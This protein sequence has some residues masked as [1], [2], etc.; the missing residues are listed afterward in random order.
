MPHEACYH[1]PY[2]KTIPQLFPQVAPIIGSDV[3]ALSVDGLGAFAKKVTVGQLADYFGGAVIPRV[4]TPEMFGAQGGT[5][6][7]TVAVQTAVNA[8]M[9]VEF[10]ASGAVVLTRLYRTSAPIT[11]TAGAIDIIAISAHCGLRLD[12]TGNGFEVGNAAATGGARIEDVRFL[13]VYVAQ[14]IVGTNGVA[15][16]VYNT[17]RLRMTNCNSVGV[18][19]CVQLGESSSNVAATDSVQQAILEGCFLST[20][21]GDAIRIPSAAIV[22]IDDCMGNASGAAGTAFVRLG[23][24][25][26]NVDGIE[27]KGCTAENFA[28]GIRC[29][30]IGAAN[31]R[32][33]D[34][35]VDRNSEGGIFLKPQAGGVIQNFAIYANEIGLNVDILL[36]V[37][38][39]MDGS[40]SGAS[41]VKGR[42]FGNNIY[43]FGGP[44]IL[45]NEV[46]GANIFG[47][48]IEDCGGF[49][50]AGECSI[51]IINTTRWT[52]RGNSTQSTGADYG[53]RWSGG[54]GGMSSA[55]LLD[56]NTIVGALVS[57]V[58]NG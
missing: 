37:G 8:A 16:R 23:D 40:L 54:S 44:G 33:H 19:H 55:Q 26:H 46:D 14:N 50:M 45:A 30:T 5:A 10:G 57:P 43:R 4:Y 11:I 53:I 3:L 20:S 41:V 49:A 22:T 2:T 58:F 24:T 17:T 6:D 1:M 15:W 38:I 34:N 27:I 47:N 13:G 28:C 31:M 51:W 29:D 48:D 12:H 42:V 7:D 25:Y 35:I 21:V 9:Q 32:I 18:K 52:V 39:T 36:N 56:Q